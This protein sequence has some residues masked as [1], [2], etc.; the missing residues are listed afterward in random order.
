MRFRRRVRASGL[1]P[2]TSSAM[3]SPM[4]L[5]IFSARSSSCAASACDSPALGGPCM[6]QPVQRSPRSSQCA[7][8]ACSHASQP[9]LLAA[10]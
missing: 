8:V 9:A 10:A 4:A 1:S 3:F 5:R 7:A 2:A 6:R